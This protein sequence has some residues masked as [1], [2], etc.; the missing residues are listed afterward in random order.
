[1]YHS[2][3]HTHWFYAINEFVFFFNYFFV[4]VLSFEDQNQAVELTNLLF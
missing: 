2:V 3:G 4:A 1:M